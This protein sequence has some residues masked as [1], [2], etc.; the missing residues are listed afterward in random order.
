MTRDFH[1][2]G[3][4][5]GDRLRRHGGDLASARIA[6]GN[7]DA[8]RR[9]Q[10]SGCRGGGGRGAVR[11]RAAH[12]RHRRRLLRLVAG[13]ASRSGATTARAAPVPRHATEALLA[14]GMREIGLSIHAVTVPGAIDAWA[15]ILEAHGRFVAR[16]RAAARHPSTPR[17]DS[18][19]RRASPPTGRAGREAA[20]DPGASRHY[21]FGG[22]SP[23]EG[24]VVKLPALAQTLRT[25]AAQGPRA[26]YEG[27]IADDIVATMAPRGSFL[28]AR[29]SPVTA[30]R[31]V[32]ADRVEL[33][34]PRR[35]RTAAQQPGAD[36]AGAAQH[37]GAFR[38]R[39]RS[40]RSGPSASISA[41]S[42]APG[43]CGARYPC[44]RSGHHAR[45]RCRTLIDKAFAETLAG[46]IDRARRVPLPRAPTPGS[47]TVYLTVV[48][49]DRM[50]VSLINS[51][52]SSVR[53]RHLHRADRHH[54]AQPRRLLRAR[55]GASQRH[56]A[57]QA[58][59]AHHHP[60]AG[61]PRRPLRDSRSASWART[62]SRWATRRSSATWSI[63][64]WTCRRRSTCRAR[65][66]SA[67]RR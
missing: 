3:R 11:G 24:D 28:R 6:D 40:T 58:P 15:A 16:P 21:L 5:P 38:S 29:I 35:G 2:P 67:S 13:P 14:Q 57:G 12:D 63:T 62:T 36:R 30:A 33:S 27:P 65:S 49:R 53:H 32:D 41:R 19:W 23:A 26:F 51:L 64:A 18:R 55:S 46:R 39:A 45:R 42:R 25:V 66:S 7:R 34:R 56:R 52:F 31:L 22:A 50:A 48:D 54:A 10:C 37:P 4:S 17:R 61:V 47:D 8:A 20:A 1:R 44:R 9:R 60:G 43:L 59:D